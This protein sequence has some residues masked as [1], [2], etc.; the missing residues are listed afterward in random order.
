MLMCQFIAQA[1]KDSYFTCYGEY[2][3]LNAVPKCGK[4]RELFKS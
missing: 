1:D 4:E 3:I 2:C